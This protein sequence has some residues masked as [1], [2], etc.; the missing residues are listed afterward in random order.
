MT[1]AE[2]ATVSAGAV[3][4]LW[5][6]RVGVV[7]GGFVVAPDRIATCAHVVAEALDADPYAPEPPAATVRVDFPLAGDG[8]D[9]PFDAVVERWSPIRDD[10][11]GDV[12]ILRLRRPAPVPVPPVRGIARLWGHGFR[13]L[14]FPEGGAGGVW[15]SGEIRGEQGTRWFQLHTGVGEPRV[16]PGFSGTPV[17]DTASGA[18]VGMTVAAVRGDTTA[19]AY[20]IPVDAVF[21]LDQ[22]LVPCPY[23]GARPFDDE[24]AAYFHGRDDDIARL[25]DATSRRAVVAVAGPSGVGKSS[26]VRAGLL[27]RLRAAGTP[28]VECR[29]DVDPVGEVASA[30]AGA[31]EGAVVVLD[32]FEELATLAP[33]TAGALLDEVITRTGTGRVRAVLTLRWAAF[34]RL[35]PRLTAALDEATV[36]VTPLDRA[37]LRDA[38]VGPAEQAP[39]LSFEDGLV[40]RILDDAGTEPGQLPL[41]SALLADLWDHRED[42][43]A[44]LRGYLEC[45]GVAG[46]LAQH[47]DRVVDS[48]AADEQTVRRLFT[49][50]AEPGRDGRFVRRPVPLADLPAEQ[51]ELAEA[52]A[53]RRLLVVSRDAVEL[54]HQALI[55]HWPRLR[56][57]LSADREFLSWL[58]G[59]QD[60]RARWESGGR[61][62]GALLRGAPLAA[63]VEWSSSRADDLTAADQEYVRCGV[64]LER[65][66]V[67]RRRVVT[68]VLAVLLLVVGSLSV[69]AVQRRDVVA[70][71]LATANAGT[72]GREA[73]ARL[74]SDPALAAQLAL[75]AWQADP[76]HPTTRDALAGAYLGLHAAVGELAELSPEPI[77]A[78]LVRGDTALLATRPHPVLVTGLAGPAPQRHELAD[79]PP[80]SGAPVLSP[81][82]RLVAVPMT[83]RPV[84]LLRDPTGQQPDRELHGARGTRPS[85]PI[86]APGGDRLMWFALSEAQTASV[87]LWDLRT[88][89]EIP[90]GIGTVPNDVTWGWPTDDPGRI[91]LRHGRFEMSDSRLV[92]RSVTDGAEV[93]TLPPGTAVAPDGGALVRIDDDTTEFTDQ[94][95]VVV[96]PAGGAGPTRRWPTAD[97]R[98]SW[99]RLSADG[100]WFL[101]RQLTAAE[102]D[103]EL[104]RMVHLAT[105]EVRQAALPRVPAADAQGAPGDLLS[106]ATSIGVVSA[107]DRTVLVRAQGTS[108]LTFDTERLPATRDP[109]RRATTSVGGTVMS[110]S[111][112]RVTTWDRR[113]GQ[114]LGEITGIPYRFMGPVLEGESLWIMSPVEAEGVWEIVRYEF[115]AL[116]PTTS[117]RIP[118]RRRA[119]NPVDL[120]YVGEEVD[121]AVDGEQV[122]ISHGGWLTA[123]DPATGQPLGEPV[124]LGDTPAE[125][126]YSSAHAHVWARPG[127]PGQ[128]AVKTADGSTQL[129][130][131]PSGRLLRTFPTTT[132]VGPVFDASGARMAMPNRDRAIEVWDV[133]EG[134]QIGPPIVL[135]EEDV[136]VVTFRP[137]GHLVLRVAA[138][139]GVEHLV[140]LLFVEPVSGRHAGEMRLADDVGTISGDQTVGLRDGTPYGPVHPNPPEV[141]ISAEGWRDALCALAD[142]PFTPAERALLPAGVDPV[143]PCS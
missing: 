90:N 107:G 85:A 113:T 53:D 39:G 80:G 55:E 30:L 105:G 115:P 49:A 23:P 94:A 56:D 108:L 73:L 118:D 11:S 133:D 137:D 96:D 124:R 114:Q 79:L 57:W 123:H 103:Y 21:A 141:R 138:G 129:R 83:D 10:G 9:E 128:V 143:P 16:E 109:D 100:G 52:L 89:A 12:A 2:R 42:G 68:A 91:L 122:V 8:A 81:D 140:R 70:T 63:A 132:E 119:P 71:Q 87:Q 47:A 127:H 116:R 104:V 95:A 136:A 59:L 67:R 93:A 50:L 92:V 37:G 69:L 126:E 28:V 75:A 142:R 18:V 46:A 36:Q 60:R 77:E 61:D 82:G 20:L 34:E 74:S 54:A 25:A 1:I 98:V 31:P 134:V 4:R 40:D 5:H 78:M 15:T 88:G 111:Y 41:V 76:D 7:G 110:T 120:F 27:P 130:E 22:S 51:R 29:L 3:V 64:A 48:L 66:R 13:V 62:D 117:F 99:S 125:T 121:L 44:T 45:G 19:A 33:E 14:G 102:A 65:R 17:W 35:D 112:T 32:Q 6:P 43:R 38:I 101:E 26:L 139:S 131:M 135:P 97:S 86:F 84:V 106:A 58:A 24:H 72:L